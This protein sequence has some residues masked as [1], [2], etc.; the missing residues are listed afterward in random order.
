MIVGIDTDF[1]VQ[2]HL[3]E[4]KNR[5]KALLLRD[6]ILGQ[7]Q[8]FAL[9]AQV[10]TEFIHVVTDP[11]RFEH[12]LSM[13][14]ALQITSVWWQSPE[15]VPIYPSAEAMKRFEFLMLEHHIERKRILDTML[16][17]TYLSA[18]VTQLITGDMADYKIFSQLQLI[19][20]VD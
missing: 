13:D 8:R 17:A 2:L 6:R 19:E 1:L 3:V 12:P 15:V 14:S 9:A 20:L 4:H 18:G 10:V 7:G 5:Q 16:A 11:R